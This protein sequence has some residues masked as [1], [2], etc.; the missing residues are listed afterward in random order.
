MNLPVSGNTYNLTNGDLRGANLALNEFNRLGGAL[1]ATSAASN[2]VTVAGTLNIAGN[3]AK[4]LSYLTVPPGRSI[5]NNGSATWGG[6]NITGQGGATLVNNGSLTVTNDPA[7]VWGGSGTTP[8]LLNLGTFTKN[9]GGGIATWSSTAITNGGVFNYNSGSLTVGGPFVQTNG[10]SFLG[11]NFNLSSNLRVEAGTLT[12]RGSV[13]GTFYN[14]GTL[15]PGTSPGF[16]AGTSFTNTAASKLNLEL[17]ATNG[18]G[19]SYDQIRLTGAATLDGTVNVSWWNN[20]VPQISNKFIVM[21]FASRTGTFPTINPPPG[22]TLQA[23]YSSTNLILTVVGLT[24]APLEITSFPS[25]QIVWTPDPVDFFVGVSG[26]TPISYQWRFNGT[27]LAGATNAGYSI[28]ASAVTNTGLYTVVITDGF[29]GTTNTSATLTV[30][31][32]N[33]TIQWTN[34]LGGNWSVPANWSPNRVPGPT[35]NAVII[36]NGTYTVAINVPAAV[37]NLTVGAGSV[38][39]TQ[40]VNLLGGQ[41]LTLGRN[42]TFAS[43]TIFGLDGT[44]Q[45]LG[46]SNYFGGLVNWYSGVLSGAGRSVVASNAS[47]YFISGLVQKNIATNILENF[48]SFTYS[49][50]SGFG[51]GQLLHFSGGAHL[52]NH[53]SGVINMSANA[54][55]YAGSQVPRS[56]LVNFGTVVTASSG[57]FS[58]S[59]L[60]IDFINYG[61][62]DNYGYVYIG[63]GTN[64]GTFKNFNGLAEFSLF[65]DPGAGEYFSFEPGTALVG[66]QVNLNCGGPVQWRAPGVLHNGRLY[67]GSGSGGASY[68]NAEFKVLVNYTNTTS[69]T[70]RRGAFT[71]ANPALITD[72][73]SYLEGYQNFWSFAV[74]NAGA[75]YVDNFGHALY[76]F[77]NSGTIFV[78]SNATFSGGV[79]YGGGGRVILSNTA[80]ATFSGGN[81][82][83]QF[84]ENY[85][86]VS[87]TGASPFTGNTRYDNKTNAQTYFG[88]GSFS[89]G[90]A[91][92]LN[93]GFI[94]GFGGIGVTATNYATIHADD[95]SLRA[96][97]VGF[98]K[99]LAGETRS[100]G[101]GLSGTLDIEAGYVGG[102]GPISGSLRN[103]STFGAGRPFGFVNISGGYS[104]TA[105]GVE[106]L[107]IKG[108]QRGTDYP[109]VNVAGTANLAGTLVVTFTNGYFPVIGNNITAMTWTA[110]SGQ[111]DQILLPNYDFDI[112]YFSNALVLRASNGLPNVVVSAPATQLVCVPFFLNASA[113]DLDG[114]VTNVT[115]FHGASVIASLPASSGK[116]RVLYDFP[117]PTTFSARA[118]DDR[119]GQKT[120]VT[121]VTY[122]TRPLHVVNLGGFFETNTAFKLCMLG[123][124]SSNYMVQ[125]AEL[126][127]NP[128]VTNWHDL[129]LMR[130]TNG[131]WR[132]SDT[133]TTNFPMRYY[134]VRQQ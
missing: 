11:S 65:G 52:T 101:G 44:L 98:L 35:N 130:Y 14:N 110:R 104:N 63:R 105:A 17:G 53:P 54:F 118:T 73:R 117:G 90:P 91:F 37:S 33:G 43:N 134:R 70:I 123:E 115:F 16:I 56:Y 87:V 12:G 23:D 38:A 58:P 78:R 41:G 126:F 7:L 125:G 13:A 28:A 88:G 34:V 133:N 128:V 85:G 116:V 1:Y 4:T 42:A 89:T 132:Y 22:A 62:L 3:T 19:T 20:Y 27:N 30:L 39:S 48:G 124:S 111:F 100:F 74:T 68:P 18:P 93:Y 36:T 25:N 112:Q 96:L 45:T 113:T 71:V 92:V 15:N 80:S 59:Y 109:Q 40:T 24:N 2:T 50:D 127:S 131:I 103:N 29:G 77:G 10:S 64:Y 107:P 84:V 55:E 119:G 60:S 57:I 86:N 31:Q 47:I 97:G 26:T 67:V 83:A 32:F 9:S 8:T 120:I 81:L 82:D 46:G 6:V 66:P 69:V 94:H 129:G 114:V 75:M 72:L 76:G 95:P 99:Q 79:L 121:N 51:P 49:G 106:H 61:L 5:I 21:T 108:A 102:D 122:V